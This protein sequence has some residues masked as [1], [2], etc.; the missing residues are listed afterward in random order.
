MSR[1]QES[2]LNMP[3]VPRAR[4]PVRADRLGVSAGG[5]GP[6]RRSRAP[7]HG[8]ASLRRVV[9]EAGREFGD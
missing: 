7:W 8:G 6:P 2:A 1:A 3:R 4:S 5:R 9:S